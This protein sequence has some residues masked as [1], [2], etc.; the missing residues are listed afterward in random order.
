MLTAQQPEVVLVF[1]RHNLLRSKSF[2][3]YLSSHMRLSPSYNEDNDDDNVTI[4]MA[5]L[6]F[7]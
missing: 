7:F 1:L 6:T 2:F 3:F 4:I 5:S